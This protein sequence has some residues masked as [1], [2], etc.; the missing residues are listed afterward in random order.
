M[1]NQPQYNDQGNVVMR[2]YNI[3]TLAQL[4]NDDLY[5]RLK[6]NNNLFRRA[7][8]AARSGRLSNNATA[9]IRHALKRIAD[10]EVPQEVT[11][12]GRRRSHT[13][14]A[15]KSQRKTRR[16]HRKSH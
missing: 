10:E 16:S 13:R 3:N 5:N 1:N 11:G 15:R 6:T 7:N 8:N 9:K 14:K 2:N 4:S 12:G